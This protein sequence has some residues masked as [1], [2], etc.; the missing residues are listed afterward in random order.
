MRIILTENFIWEK[1]FLWQ[2]QWPHQKNT[3]K[4]DTPASN[5]QN[6]DFFNFFNS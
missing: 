2:F 1:N 5:S 4:Y 3:I 6:N